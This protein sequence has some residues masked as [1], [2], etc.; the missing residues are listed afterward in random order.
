MIR[1]PLQNMGKGAISPIISV[2]LPVYNSEKYIAEAIESI[3]YQTYR[4][5][6]FII[7]DDGSSDGT[8]AILQEYQGKDSRIRLISRENKGV[9][10]TL[11]EGINLV[12]GE[13]IALMNADDIALPYRFECQLQWLAQ[14]DA[15]ICGSWVKLFGTADERIIKYP[16]T[17]QAIKIALL[18]SS[19]FA[20][21]SVMMKT[22]LVK[23]LLYDNAYDKGAEDYDLWERAAH[24]GW[25]MTNVQEVLLLYR[26]HT[27]QITKRFFNENHML[28]Q[29]VRRRYWEF[30]SNSILLDQDWIDEVMKIREPL[31]PKIN[32]DYIDSAFTELLQRNYGEARNTI[33]DHATRLYFRVAADC[34]DIVARWTSLNK[35]FGSG[36]ALGTKLK[37]WLL[38]MLSIRSDSAFFHRLKKLYFP[39]IR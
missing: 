19:P 24:K 6:E 39:F 30:V 9:V 1:V 17:D 7:I 32:M 4:N 18:F 15:D 29:K 10:S 28:S 13:W 20:Q 35:K 14:T 3:L 22:V 23:Q 21:P 31:L 8:L 5:F 12:C 34:P 26:Q 37:L 16:Q 2:V 25:Q 33:F 36:F 11:N 38:N 27:T